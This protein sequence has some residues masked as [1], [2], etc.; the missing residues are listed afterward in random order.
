MSWYPYRTT[1][2]FLTRTLPEFSLN[3]PSASVSLFPSLPSPAP[4]AP[5]TSDAHCCPDMASTPLCLL[6]WSG[7][8]ACK[9]WP[10]FCLWPKLNS[11]RKTQTQSH[12]LKTFISLSTSLSQSSLFML[13]KH[14]KYIHHLSF[15]LANLFPEG[16]PRSLSHSLIADT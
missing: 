15:S 2:N 1:P 3:S 8:S 14:L 12:F 13:P 10:N 16:G 9:A 5:V 7:F 4:Y 6:Q 11:P